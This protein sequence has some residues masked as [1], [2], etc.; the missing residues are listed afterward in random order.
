MSESIRVVDNDGNTT[1]NG[2]HWPDA[3]AGEN[4][5]ARKFAIENNGTRP[6]GASPGPA[7]GM[8]IAIQQVINS[9]ASINDG[10]TMLRIGADTATL[11]PPFSLLAVLGPTADGGVWGSIGTR[12]YRVTALNANGET[13]WFPHWRST[14]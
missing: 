3:F 13:I 8:Q 5:V 2:E 1:L 12:G 7:A 14:P 6:L 10:S 9:D 4:Q 11:S